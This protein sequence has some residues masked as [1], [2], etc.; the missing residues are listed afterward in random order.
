LVQLLRV[1]VWFPGDGSYNRC[2]NISFVL[3]LF[4]YF[5]ADPCE[6][7]LNFFKCQ[8]FL[9]RLFIHYV[10]FLGHDFNKPSPEELV[11]INF[12]EQLLKRELRANGLKE[13]IGTMPQGHSPAPDSFH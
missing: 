6:T 1:Q 12:T 4:A 10:Y 2:K 8:G 9:Q 7:N 3:T 5:V 13:R 11:A